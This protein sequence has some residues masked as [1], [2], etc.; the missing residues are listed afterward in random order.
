ME[1]QNNQST[2]VEYIHATE[3]IRILQIRIPQLALGKLTEKKK[4]KNRNVDMYM[5]WNH[6]KDSLAD[7]NSNHYRAVGGW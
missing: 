5:V 6:R 1:K 2:K 3:V 7:L 4:Q